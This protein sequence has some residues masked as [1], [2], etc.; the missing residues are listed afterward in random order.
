MFSW[1][2]NAIKLVRSS[3]RITKDVKIQD[4]LQLSFKQTLF[5]LGKQ[6]DTQI[7]KFNSR[8]YTLGLQLPPYSKLSQLSY[9]SG[10][11][12]A[13]CCRECSAWH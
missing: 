1:M 11:S 2:T 10:C 6:Q 9:G 8:P 5:V 4:G 13:F 12:H 7:V 3:C